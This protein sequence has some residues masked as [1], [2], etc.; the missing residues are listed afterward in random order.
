V[1]FGVSLTASWYNQAG[2]LV[3][4]YTDGSIHLNHAGTEA[5]QGAPF[6]CFAYSARRSLRSASTC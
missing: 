3:H 2:A 1:K 6:Y 4:I 5:G